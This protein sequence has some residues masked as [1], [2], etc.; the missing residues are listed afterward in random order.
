VLPVTLMTLD[1][2]V[3]PRWRAT[4]TALFVAGFWR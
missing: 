3:T 4:V 1:I 2:R